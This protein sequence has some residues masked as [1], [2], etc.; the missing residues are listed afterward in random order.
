M[1]AKI[2]FKTSSIKIDPQRARLNVILAFMAPN[3][4]RAKPRLHQASVLRGK[5]A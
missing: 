3:N 1:L 2:P 4:L 5:W